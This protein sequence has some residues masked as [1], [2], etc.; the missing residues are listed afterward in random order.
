[1]NLSRRTAW[2]ATALSG[3]VAL[4]AW[5]AHRGETNLW[6]L[7]IA[8]LAIV[9]LVLPRWP[10][11]RQLAG[12]RL[13]TELLLF[14]AVA[15]LSQA[16]AV[17]LWRFATTPQVRVW[18]V[19]HY[20]LGA[21]YF[22]E[23]GYHD[24][25]DATLAA[26]REGED[27]WRDVRR[28]RNLRTY[29]KE[30]RSAAELRYRPREHFSPAR[31]EEF[32]RDVEALQRQLPADD[33]RGVFIDRGYNPSPFW[34]VVG[35]VLTLLLPATKTWAL[36]I[37]CS[38]DLVFL[39]A[40]FVLAGRVFGLR[41]AALVLL[42]FTLT[43]V[44]NARLIGGFLQYDWF[45]A[46][47]AGFCLLRRGRPWPAGVLAAYA[48]LAR[49]F[50][51]VFVASAAIPLA[52]RWV[53]TGSLRRARLALFLA[54]SLTGALGL[55]L[56]CLT[57]RGA[58]AWPEFVA[59]LKHHSSEHLYGERR[60]G[61]KHVFTHDV[62]SLDLDESQS[63]RRRLYAR[64]EG[65]Y[66][67]AGALL[68]SFFFAAVR[69]RSVPDAF[70]FGL[71]PFFVLAVSSRYYWACLA[72]L[73]LLARPGP[74]GRRRVRTLDVAQASIYGLY[75]F[76]ALYRA[77]RYAAYS[78]FN[79]LLIAFF[80]ILMAVY[81]V[82]DLKAYRRR[83]GSDPR[84][85]GP[86]WHR[87]RALLVLF[88]VAL[89][90][91][92]CF[93][94][95]PLADYPIRDVDE[96]VSAL[97][98]ASWLEGGVPYR[99]A[100]D[101]RGP[102]T[103]L[104]YAVIFAVAGVHNMWAVHW[105]LLLL[106]LLACLLLWRFARELEA[107]SSGVA[108]GYLAALLL[109]VCSYTY[110]RSQMLAFHTEWPLM[111]FATLGMMA[112]WWGI[113]RDD[114]RFLVLAGAGF[115]LGFL[116]KQ[117]GIFD[118]AAGGGFLLLWQWHQGR[119][120]SRATVVRVSLLAGGFLAMLAA[121]IAYFAAAGA[122]ADFYLYFWS[123]NV[124]HY[125]RVV[126]VLERLANLD[127]FAHSRHYL[128]ANPLLLVAV[129]IQVPAAAWGLVARR[130][131]DARLLVVLWFLFAYLGASYSGRNFGHYFIQI[132]PAACLLAAWTVRD[133]W[134]ALAS[135]KPG[136]RSLRD[137]APA[138]R[139][140]LAAAVA[141][142]LI[143][144]LVRFGRDIAWF[145]VWRRA[146]TDEVRRDLL[147]AIER[148]TSPEDTIFVW[149]YYPE[150]Y[151]LSGRRPATR[152]SNTNY[153]T[154]MLPWE[155]HRPE[156]DTSAHIVPGSWEILMRELEASRPQLIVDTAAG[157]HRYYRKYPIAELPLLERYLEEHY[158]PA[159]TVRDREQEPGCVVWVRRP[160][161]QRSPG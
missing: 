10:R 100:I 150:L 133:A 13:R 80:V 17:D 48:V 47:A 159:A 121:A 67:A 21:K 95:L 117:P 140:L 136:W 148:W 81:L 11:W 19:Y 69:R 156:V 51:A 7:L 37:L 53:R 50:P 146:P 58:G 113:R 129:V 23:L 32:S 3:A 24:L 30:P 99:D 9:V 135:E 130:R 147:A 161:R 85:A 12:T 132:L 112:L 93:L 134:T 18:N 149:G 101:Q 105:G 70:L 111:L 40:T 76:Y 15:S 68:L 57:A 90:L 131:V 139:G 63:D 158:R 153:L 143:L 110:R 89:F 2:R 97:I 77:D 41:S 115:G 8:A 61:L 127:P 36:K 109:A 123:Y 29:R 59:N 62:R 71:L 154:G 43:P 38:L 151:V 4:G 145:N 28:V 46:L 44:N 83:S 103:Y 144:P 79:L 49:G 114:K 104:I 56:G 31:W 119:L 102:V 33:W 128:T 106:I 14:L 118:A 5:A 66:L 22:D 108:L 84:E 94:R 64:Q 73:P 26:D 120:V 74:S 72:L 152:Y 125:T 52:V 142:A 54:L 88:T 39:A 6:R 160:D 107:G 126:T 98:A 138:S 92:L 1:M 45:C 86:P 20:Y 155:N 60:V 42:F 116:S 35:R 16:T 157:N 122:L 75:Y 82:G 91:L 34:T 137:L 87:S 55:A 124:E 96:S 78:I 141:L 25:Y 27:Y 65:L